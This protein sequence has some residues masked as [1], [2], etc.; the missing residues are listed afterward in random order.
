MNFYDL[1]VHVQPETG[2]SAEELA[3]IA[4]KYGYAAVAAV[5][6]AKRPEAKLPGLVCGIEL[7]AG[8]VSELKN[9]ILN[10][11]KETDLLLVHGGDLEINR[12]ASSDSR[13]DILAHPGSIDHITARFASENGVALEFNMD[14]VI[15]ARGE[16]RAKTLHAMRG[17]LELVRKYDT[18]FVITSNATSIYGLRAPG[19]MLALGMLVGMSKEEAERGVSTVPEGI[20]SQSPHS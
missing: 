9:K 17:N 12:A 6:H 1:N 11:R 7:V 4:S 13:V 18:P 10:L 19:E 8:N 14:A 2:L 15:F 5:T 3:G 16:R 20:L